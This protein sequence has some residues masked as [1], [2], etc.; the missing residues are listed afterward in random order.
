MQT[1]G[2]RGEVV[3]LAVTVRCIPGVTVKREDWPS[4][5]GGKM[6]EGDILVTGD[7]QA[8]RSSVMTPSRF[9]TLCL[10]G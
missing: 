9:R 10:D 2:K 5:C 8:L 6:R 4:S 3:K 7:L 1:Q